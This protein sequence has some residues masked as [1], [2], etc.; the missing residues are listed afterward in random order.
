MIDLDLFKRRLVCVLS[1][2]DDEHELP[3]DYVI[4]TG[5]GRFEAVA[6]N[7]LDGL[8]E[9]SPGIARERSLGIFDDRDTAIKVLQDY[10][11][12]VRAAEHADWVTEDGHFNFNKPTVN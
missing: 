11:A 10:V 12:R 6:T 7:L 4:R 5:D 9:D 1:W 3:W 2:F 8:T